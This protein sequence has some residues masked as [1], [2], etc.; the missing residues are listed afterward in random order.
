MD[1][2]ENAERKK[3]NSAVHPTFCSILNDV[4][5]YYCNVQPT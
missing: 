4:E 2:R 5:K 1:R 3:A